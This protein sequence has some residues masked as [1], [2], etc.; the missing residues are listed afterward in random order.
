MQLRD[1][2]GAQ[3]PFT[4]NPPLYPRRPLSPGA[5][6]LLTSMSVAGLPH[7]SSQH[8]HPLGARRTAGAIVVRRGPLPATG[9]RSA[10]TAAT[11]PATSRNA[12]RPREPDCPRTSGTADC[13]SRS[14]F[15]AES[16]ARA[17][18]SALQSLSH[19]T[20][21]STRALFRTTHCAQP[22]AGSA[23]AAKFRD[24]FPT[25]LRLADYRLG[26][27]TPSP[28]AL[29]PNIARGCLLC[30]P[31]PGPGVDDPKAG[32]DSAPRKKQLAA[33]AR[34][35]P[36]WRRPPAEPPDGRRK[37]PSGANRSAARSSHGLSSG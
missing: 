36:A 29:G 1:A 34:Y 33:A 20:A 15:D 28:A 35:G 25:F 17:A 23:A 19:S 32:S 12:A 3:H 27:T 37:R 11:T 14:A 24:D 4:F 8:H 26:P 30:H 9:P 22:F 31:S 13:I 2:G 18:A 21:G 10:S 5:S 7:H 16:P 6:D